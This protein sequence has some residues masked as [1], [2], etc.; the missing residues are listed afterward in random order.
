MPSQH[1]YHYE[2]ASS[3][4]YER[5]LA[6]VQFASSRYSFLLYALGDRADNF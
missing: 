6:V 5:A 1:Q 2:P 3:M 4:T